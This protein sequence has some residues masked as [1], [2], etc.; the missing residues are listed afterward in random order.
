MGPISC[1]DLLDQPYIHGYI[2][3]KKISLCQEGVDLKPDFCQFGEQYRAPSMKNIFCHIGLT[4]LL[5][6][7]IVNIIVHVALKYFSSNRAH[8]DKIE[9]DQRMLTS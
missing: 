9:N 4:L 8:R 3:A 1:H 7:P 5:W 2:H 6:M